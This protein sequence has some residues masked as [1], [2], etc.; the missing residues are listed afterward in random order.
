MNIIIFPLQPRIFY[1]LKNE[2][3]NKGC[4][5]GRNNIILYIH[6]ILLRKVSSTYFV[7]GGH[8]FN[9]IALVFSKL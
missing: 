9:E 6:S 7:Q 5:N 3:T 4:F 1:D 2:M 8:F